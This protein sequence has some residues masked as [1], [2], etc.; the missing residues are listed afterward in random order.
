[1]SVD[2]GKSLIPS[3]VLQYLKVVEFFKFFMKIYLYMYVRE[4]CC[5]SSTIVWFC[6]ECPYVLGVYSRIAS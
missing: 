1:M 4:E 3:F 6:H 5:L 2:L